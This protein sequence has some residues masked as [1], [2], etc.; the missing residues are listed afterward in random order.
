MIDPDRLAAKLEHGMRRHRVPGAALGLLHPDGDVQICRGITSVEQPL[1]V[2]PETLFQIG[3]TTKT[4]TAIACLRLVEAGL[5]ELEAPVRRYLP[6]WRVAD[7][8]VSAKVRIRHL[9]QHTSGFDGAEHNFPDGDGW[10][11]SALAEWV[12]GMERLEQVVSLGEYA[13]NNS[14]FAL[15]G[16]IV[17]TLRDTTYE[18]AATELVLEPLGMRRSLFSPMQVMLHR[19]AVGHWVDGDVK[20]ARPWNIPRAGNPGGGLASSLED[21]LRYARLAM[22]DG[23]PL[24]APETTE[25]MRTPEVAAEDGWRVGLGWF[26]LDGGVRVIS[27]GGGT[28]GQSAELW[29]APDHGVGLVVLTNADSGRML[30]EELTGVVR[31]EIFGL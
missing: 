23:A 26:V 24:L 7:E 5:I 18:R 19:F 27:H 6:E 15:L 14:A 4:V 2:T 3:S 16:H 30:K 12:A 31:R 13:Y 22:G 29:V 17:A 9:L 11:D 1:P 25:L 28:T 8:R 10:C 21:Q 20:V